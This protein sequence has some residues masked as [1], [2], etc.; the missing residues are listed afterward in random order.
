[1]TGLH[2]PR[3]EFIG[4]DLFNALIAFRLEIER[5][6]ARL[7]CAGSRR[8]V[9]PSGMSREMGGGRKAYIT[10][11]GDRGRP[12]NLIDIFDGAEADLVSTVEEQKTF[13]EK[14]VQ[15]IL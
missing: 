11:I 4:A 14:W 10:H 1:V 15:S 13:H 7:L 2:L 6:G 9:F 3:S 12:E 5:I 8:D